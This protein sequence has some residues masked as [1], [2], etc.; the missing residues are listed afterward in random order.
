VSESVSADV[1]SKRAGEA[2]EARVLEEIAELRNV[3]D[4]TAEWH[5]AEVESLLEPSERVVFCGINLLAAGTP[6]EIKSAQ[7]RLASGQRGRFYLR[8]RQHERLLDAAASYLFAVYNPRDRSVEAIA[9]MPASLVDELL[10]D[11]WTSVDADR[12]ERGYRQL[13]WSRV[14]DPAEVTEA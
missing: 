11:G 4:A 1:P 5:D 3:T 10:P 13:G 7:T 14:F 8:Q 12:S 2:V 6:V 9:I